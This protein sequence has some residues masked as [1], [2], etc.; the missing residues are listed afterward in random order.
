MKVPG[1]LNR[2]FWLAILR[3]FGSQIDCAK[4]TGVGQ[5]RLSE[6]QRNHRRPGKDEIQKLRKFFSDGQL[7]RFFGRAA[8]DRVPKINGEHEHVSE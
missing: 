4:I 1:E 7:A 8:I 2:E 3:Q 6:L 5:T